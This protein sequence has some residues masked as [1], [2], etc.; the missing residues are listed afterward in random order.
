MNQLKIEIPFCLLMAEREDEQGFSKRPTCTLSQSTICG[1]DTCLLASAEKR[2]WNISVAH[3]PGSEKNYSGN[4]C[5]P[6]EAGCAPAVYA[7]RLRPHLEKRK[8]LYGWKLTGMSN[9]SSVIP[10]QRTLMAVDLN[11][12]LFRCGYREL[13][14]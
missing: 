10:H 6:S 12:N 3:G 8:W 11:E 13:E 2:G 7:R 1:I 5:E 9:F 4:R 14:P